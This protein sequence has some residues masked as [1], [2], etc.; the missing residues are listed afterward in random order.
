MFCFHRVSNPEPSSPCRIS[1]TAP[2]ASLLR[3]GIRGSRNVGRVREASMGGLNWEEINDVT[4]RVVLYGCAT[5]SVALRVFE[6]GVLREVV[7]CVRE[8][9]TGEWRKLQNDELHDL[10]CS[11]NI[12]CLMES[13]MD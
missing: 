13:R 4:L 2:L 6:D 10:C 9:V 8:K 11:S 12:T 1:I 3:I 7:G 5:W